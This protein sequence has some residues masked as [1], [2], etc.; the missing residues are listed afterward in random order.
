MASA[1]PNTS[2]GAKIGIIAGRGDLPLLLARRL[3]EQGRSFYLLLVKGEADPA[4]YEGYPHDVI[5]ITKI[6]KFLKALK[7]EGCRQVTLVGPIARPDFKN[8]IP[9]TEGF[10]LLKKIGSSFSKGDDGLLRAITEFVEE[11]GFEIIGAHELEDGFLA[12]VGV[13]GAIKPNDDD[14]SDITRGIDVA[15]AVGA[16]D[17][18][19][20]IVIRDGYVLA[21][22]AAEGSE[23]LIARCADFAQATPAGV[24]IKLSK[25]A[26]ELRAD[27]PTIGPETIRQIKA[28][29]LKGIVIEA[30][31][32]LVLDKDAVIKAA[33]AAGIFIKAV[34][35]ESANDE[36]G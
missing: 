13:L 14:Q 9:D 29:H 24:F 10:K 8:I 35:C 19:Q 23:K 18:G 15:K 22:E 32:T 1:G 25:P 30:G 12:P 2:T 27:M 20:A 11:K 4:D 33:N 7:R 31:K 6:G 34:N 17:I 3:A 5:A 36:H 21:V 16:L 28:A 26:Q